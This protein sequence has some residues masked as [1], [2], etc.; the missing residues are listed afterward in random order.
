VRGGHGRG[1][2]KGRG[3]GGGGGYGGGGGGNGDGGTNEHR[4]G[5]GGPMLP[6]VVLSGMHTLER[7]K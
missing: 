1:G 2:W 5:A 3:N 4:R 6:Q 7:E